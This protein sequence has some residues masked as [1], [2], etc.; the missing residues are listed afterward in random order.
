L[1][2]AAL[3][4]GGLAFRAADGRVLLLAMALIA[5]L[6]VQS[7]LGAGVLHRLSFLEYYLLWTLN[8][9]LLLSMSK[10]ASR[11]D[12]EAVFSF[13][14]HFSFLLGACCVVGILRRVAGIEQDANF[15]PMMNR[16]GTAFI[17]VLGIPICLLCYDA[18]RIG[19]LSLWFLLA[20]FAACLALMGSRMGLV[21]MA[22]SFAA[23]YVL[24][25]EGR[26]D[27]LL[28]GTLVFSVA[29]GAFVGIVAATPLGPSM[30]E[31]FET[32][33]QTVTRFLKQEDFTNA[34]SDY[35]R[36]RLTR[37]GMDLIREYPV[38]GTGVGIENYREKA[39]DFNS[40][41]MLSKP[42]NFYVSYMA[43]FGVIGFG[44][45]LAL[46]ASVWRRFQ[47]AHFQSH[48]LKSVRCAYRTMFVS[49]AVMLTMNE[50]ITMPLVWFLWG[51]GL[52][53]LP[54]AT[55][56]HG[57]RANVLRRGSLTEACP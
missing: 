25:S 32:T 24:R 28:G 36:V 33:L 11:L 41:V 42:H 55:L 43:E 34:E 6:P 9:L 49:C 15:M 47:S 57:A 39:Q 45:L 10:V 38:F 19:A 50:Y 26:L 27:R 16:N 22:T 48:E 20:V 7:L 40:D 35:K 51:V 53:A 30:Y 56:A 21:G 18:R 54:A 52:G 17:L 23:Y 5:Y 14:R 46:L 29:V 44:V 31:R 3:W 37:C 1:Q 2:L 4:H 13:F 12:R 8:T